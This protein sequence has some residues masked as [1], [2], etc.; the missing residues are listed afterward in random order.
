MK[1]NLKIAIGL[2]LMAVVT[3]VVV[4]AY[5]SITG[6]M[7]GGSPSLT[8]EEWNSRIDYINSQISYASTPPRTVSFLFMF[9]PQIRLENNGTA[10]YPNTGIRFEIDGP[11]N[12]NKKQMVN[13]G[14]IRP[15]ESITLFAQYFTEWLPTSEQ[16]P[17][18]NVTVTI[19]NQNNQNTI[20]NIHLTPPASYNS[21]WMP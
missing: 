4:L 6:N 11:I 8:A 19:P 13:S 10:T 9:E 5:T 17:T 16:F 18:F 21:T 20:L 2:V 7:L 15:H 12:G 3:A 1:K 14:D